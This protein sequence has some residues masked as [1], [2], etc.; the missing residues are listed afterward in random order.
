[1]EHGGDD[2]GSE[3]LSRR[4]RKAL[5]EAAEAWLV[6]GEPSAQDL[7][8]ARL[9]CGEPI[10]KH[11]ANATGQR[12]NQPAGYQTSHPG[13][14]KCK[15]HGGA[16]KFENMKGAWVMG[17]A[18]AKE[19]NITPWQGLLGEV[20][21]TAG[22]VAWLDLKLAQ[23]EDDDAL[24]PGGNAYDWVRMQE[25]ERQHL[26]RVSKMALDAGVAEQLVAQYRL[27]ADVMWTIMMKALNP[28]G[29]DE[30]TML[31][32]RARIARE[33]LA[34]EAAMEGATIDGTVV[35]E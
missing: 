11:N 28:L 32:V 5:Q 3:R 10:R 25:R 2:G 9:N 13:V 22:R 16:S 12:C 19:L 17:H 14:G 8:G 34:I 4:Q 26:A 33:A 29:L 24:R 21:R 23:T 30:E 35:E 27:E 15:G 1:M 6:L 20:R 18:Y 31:T 7:L